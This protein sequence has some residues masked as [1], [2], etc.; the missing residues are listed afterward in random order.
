MVIDYREQLNTPA[1]D[2]SVG[3]QDAGVTLADL[4]LAK[5]RRGGRGLRR[6]VGEGRLR[7]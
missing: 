3:V 2:P 5:V 6:V 7:E 1:G 4:D